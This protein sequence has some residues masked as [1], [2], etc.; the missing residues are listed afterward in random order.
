MTDT[1]TAPQAVFSSPLYIKGAPMSVTFTESDAE[2]VTSNLPAATLSAVFT[3]ADGAQTTVNFPVPPVSQ[4]INSSPSVT[5]TS[6]A[7]SSGRVWTVTAG[8]LTA[9]ATA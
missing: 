7:D 5:L 8:T 4:T 1:W 6:V 2:S 9:T 3:A